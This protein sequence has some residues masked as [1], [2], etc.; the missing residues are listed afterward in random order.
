MFFDVH[1]EEVDRTSV[2]RWG[3]SHVSF[4]GSVSDGDAKFRP[5]RATMDL[6]VRS[7]RLA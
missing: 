5:E 3:A 2:A 4:P 1:G 7:S 6:A